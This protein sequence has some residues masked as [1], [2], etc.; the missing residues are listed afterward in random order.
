MRTLKQFIARGV[1]INFGPYK[2]QLKIGRVRSAL[3]N[4]TGLLGD[5]DF[6]QAIY[7]RY[8]YPFLAAMG[9]V[10]N[11]GNASAVLRCYLEILPAI[12]EGSREVC[13][14]N[15]LHRLQSQTTDHELKTAA[16][17]EIARSDLRSGIPDRY[18]AGRKR[19]I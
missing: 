5:L 17:K 14:R 16:V 9:M 8:K 2:L 7:V 3:P 18:A 6:R 1:S 13:V 10:I 19:S 4:D 11:R 12:D 15:A